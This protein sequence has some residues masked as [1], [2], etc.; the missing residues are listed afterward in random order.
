MSAETDDRSIALMITSVGMG[1]ADPALQQKLLKTYLALLEQ[2][3]T[4]PG[5][6]C[7]YT[8][9]VQLVVEGS[10]VL[11]LLRSLESRGVH[12]IVCKTCLDFFGLAERV[13]VGVVGG[14]GDIISAQWKADK[15]ITL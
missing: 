14:M 11:D 8:E 15:V 13:R 4:L 10:P 2:N 1:N 5:V 3:D 12:M 7:L 6:V 9:G